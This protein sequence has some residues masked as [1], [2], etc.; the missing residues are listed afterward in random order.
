MGNQWWDQD[1]IDFYDGRTSSRESLASDVDRE[2]WDLGA[3]MVHV[4]LV[5]NGGLLGTIE[6]NRETSGPYIADALTAL[7]A[8]GLTDAADLVARAEAA[9]LAM[10]PNDCG[11]DLTEEQEELWDE[12]DEAWWPVGEQIERVVAA[13]VAALG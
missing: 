2:R 12:L 5:D 13:R 1:L 11:D 8:L 10:R 4:G 9:Y 3:V 7:R 6:N